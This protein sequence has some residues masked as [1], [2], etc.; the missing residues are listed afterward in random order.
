M[1]AQGSGDDESICDHIQRWLSSI[2]V[3]AI[4]PYIY[5][6]IPFAI[7][8][9]NLTAGIVRIVYSIYLNKATPRPFVI[10]L[11]TLVDILFFLGL[12]FFLLK[13]KQDATEYLLDLELSG[14]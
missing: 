9:L 10:T 8:L 1:D 2:I 3:S 6:V 5:P 14:V 4:R 7:L 13:A 12:L 11:C